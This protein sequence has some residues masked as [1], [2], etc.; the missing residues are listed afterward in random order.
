MVHSTYVNS[1]ILM[2][3]DLIKSDTT[4]IQY[5]FHFNSMSL[6]IHSSFTVCILPPLD[7]IPG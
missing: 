2:L 1:T 4:K 5:A 3:I 6:L 7:P